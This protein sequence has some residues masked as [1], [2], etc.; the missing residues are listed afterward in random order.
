MRKDW[1]RLAIL[2]RGLLTVQQLEEVERWARVGDLPLFEKIYRSAFAALERVL[3]A[4]DSI[5][6][7]AADARRDRLKSKIDHLKP[8]LNLR[9]LDVMI[10]SKSQHSVRVALYRLGSLPFP[11]LLLGDKNEQSE[12]E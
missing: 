2:D 12:S 9:L 5:T 6:Q 10:P 3:T 1:L 11:L 8:T 7:E 4:N